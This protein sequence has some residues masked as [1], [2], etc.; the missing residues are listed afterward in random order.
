VVQTDIKH[1]LAQTCLLIAYDWQLQGA[2]SIRRGGPGGL[3]SPS[4]QGGPSVG[5]RDPGESLR[6]PCVMKGN[7]QGLTTPS[8]VTRGHQ[9]EEM[10]C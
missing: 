2:P 5:E 4:P 7:K 8:K 9:E 10:R 3:T 1:L 6:A